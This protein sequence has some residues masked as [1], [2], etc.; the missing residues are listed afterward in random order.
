MDDCSHLLSCRWNTLMLQ[1]SQAAPC[2]AWEESFA[3][4]RNA[5]WASPCV[6]SLLHMCHPCYTRED[7]G[8]AKKWKAAGVM[9]Q[10]QLEKSLWELNSTY[11]TEN[12]VKLF[13]LIKQRLK[14]TAVRWY[15]VRFSVPRKCKAPQHQKHKCWTGS[16]WSL[17]QTFSR[18]SQVQCILFMYRG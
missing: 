5:C 9:K 14:I 7:A 6:P 11:V 8:S 17:E 2:S 10:L 4:F 16:V 1:A 18:C 13:F 3:H 15:M 12:V